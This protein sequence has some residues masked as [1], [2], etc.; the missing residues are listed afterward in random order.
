MCHLQ[1]KA[2]CALLLDSN[3]LVQRNT[4]EIVLFFF[5]LHTCLVS[6]SYQ[7]EVPGISEERWAGSTSVSVSGGEQLLRDRHLLSASG[8]SC[9][10]V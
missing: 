3:V 8:R 4:L 5:P 9:S 1:V 6:W 7:G 10:R 2:L